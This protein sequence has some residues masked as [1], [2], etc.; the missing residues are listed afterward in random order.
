MAK[1]RFTPLDL[2]RVQIPTTLRGYHRETVDRLVAGVAEQ[3][4]SLLVEVK[5]L[6]RLNE[7]ASKELERFRAQE[8]TLR[9]AL[10]LAQKAADD[11]RTAARREADSAVEAARLEASEIRQ[12][13]LEATAAAHWE[14]QKLDDEKRAFEAR[15]RALLHE[16]LE[17]LGPAKPVL[18]VAAADAFAS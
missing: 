12:K 5:E 10:V 11:T 13:A 3:L 17:R 14:L 8:A 9:E 15:F 6:R 18:E 1:E 4:E 16:H 2:E 7:L